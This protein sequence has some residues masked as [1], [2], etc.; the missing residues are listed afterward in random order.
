LPAPELERAVTAAVVGLLSDLSRLAQATAEY[1]FSVPEFEY[2]FNAARQR[3][4][5]VSGC[6]TLT[7]MDM[8]PRSGFSTAHYHKT[9]SCIYWVSKWPLP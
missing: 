7:E 1:G 8:W 2:L 5:S 6:L 4:C 9:R 3:M